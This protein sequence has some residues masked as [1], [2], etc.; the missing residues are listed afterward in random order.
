MNVPDII[1]RHALSFA[2]FLP[3][4]NRTSFEI[5]PM[6]MYDGQALYFAFHERR[7]LSDVRMIGMIVA[8]EPL[9]A[10]LPSRELLP[11]P[12]SVSSLAKGTCY[13]HHQSP[14]QSSEYSL[15]PLEL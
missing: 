2:A 14:V 15:S 3:G 7:G 11:L 13:L 9:V 12:K 10:P 8:V 4:T 5:F 1:G 6:V